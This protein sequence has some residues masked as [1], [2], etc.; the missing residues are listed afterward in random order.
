MLAGVLA[1]STTP[2][3]T[4]GARLTLSTFFKLYRLGPLTRIKTQSARDLLCAAAPQGQLQHTH[5]VLQSKQPIALVPTVATAAVPVVFQWLWVDSAAAA[6]V[7]LNV[8]DWLVDPKDLLF[9]SP[10]VAV[11][12]AG[13]ALILF[14]KLIRVRGR[15]STAYSTP[16]LWAS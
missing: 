15:L 10:V 7:C 4:S 14:P 11:G 9:H 12:V 2:V 3:H 13:L 8:P 1:C 5:P 16:L 6:T